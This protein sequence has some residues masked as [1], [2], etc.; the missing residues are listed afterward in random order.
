MKESFVVTYFGI[1][2]QSQGDGI[3]LDDLGPEAAGVL[4]ELSQ[5][6]DGIDGGKARIVLD[7]VAERHAGGR[8]AFEDDGPLSRPRRVQ[9]RREPRGPGADDQDI[10]FDIVQHGCDL[11]A[12]STNIGRPE[13]IPQS[14]A[15]PRGWQA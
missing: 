5:E 12:Y 7:L 2:V 14:S 8:P 6:L 11:W 9:R 1:R 4:N 15:T 13:P 3:P 10:G